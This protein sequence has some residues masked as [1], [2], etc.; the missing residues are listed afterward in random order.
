MRGDILFFRDPDLISR[1]IQWW[2]SGPYNHVAVDMGDGTCIGALTRGV[3]R[4]PDSK[5][6]A[7]ARPPFSTLPA[8]KL[9]AALAWLVEQEKVAYSWADIANN[10]LPKWLPVGLRF[11]QR[12]AYDCSDLV[13]RFLDLAEVLSLAD[14]GGDADVVTPNDLYRACLVRKW[15]VEPL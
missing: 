3:S 10:L 1:I 13:A 6:A 4:V 5:A 11:Q 8:E 12:R 15:I 2:T 7:R 14:L 9:D